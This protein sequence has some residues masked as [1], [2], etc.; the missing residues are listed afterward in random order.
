MDLDKLLEALDPKK[1][2]DWVQE[3]LTEAGISSVEM[4]RDDNKVEKAAKYTYKK[5]PFIP[6]RLAVKAIIGKKGFIKLIFQIRDKMLE[7]GSM[8][9]SWMSTN[10]FKTWFSEKTEQV[11]SQVI[12][13]TSH[14]QQDFLENQNIEGAKG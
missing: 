9:L 3:S 13:S 6:A 2:R 5:I 12:V 7:E 4:L 11:H 1:L 8:D 10:T 14:T